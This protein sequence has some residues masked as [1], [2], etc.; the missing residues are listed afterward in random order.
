[1]NDSYLHGD[2]HV[3]LVGYVSLVLLAF[4]LTSFLHYS[5][6]HVK[7]AATWR[8]YTKKGPSVKPE[9]PITTNERLAYEKSRESP[10]LTIFGPCLERLLPVGFDFLQSIL[11]DAR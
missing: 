5:T 6:A 4:Y 3:D 2:D 11:D 10:S 8:Y 1:M 9:S 7:A